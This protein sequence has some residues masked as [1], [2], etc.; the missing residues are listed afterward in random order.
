MGRRR[1]KQ[2][3]R[4]G[5]RHPTLGMAFGFTGFVLGLVALIVALSSS[6]D[7]LSRHTVVRK[8]D[9]APGAV[10][11]KALARG[12]VH[13]RALAKGAVKSKALAKEAVNA[14]GLAKG[15]V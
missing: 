12:A 6:A 7:A 1:R 15:A 11:A 2:M 9:I 8:G 14:N 10:T 5:L 3:V 4:S 13:P